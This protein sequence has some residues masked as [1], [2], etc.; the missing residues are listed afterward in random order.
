[1]TGEVAQ[2]PHHI[3]TKVNQWLYDGVTYRK[4]CANLE[5][6]GYP[7]FVHQYIQRWTKRGYQLWLHEREQ[8]RYRLPL[9]LDR[10]EGRGEVSSCECAGPPASQKPIAVN[11]A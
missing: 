9:R 6:L 8:R 2:L 11:C 1:M 10:G 3:R 7:G 5:Q 4:I